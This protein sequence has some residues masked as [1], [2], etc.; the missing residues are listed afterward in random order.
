MQ[1]HALELH[2]D[3]PV[4]TLYDKNY[5]QNPTLSMFLNHT[6][7]VCRITGRALQSLSSKLFQRIQW[8]K[9]NSERK[10]SLWWQNLKL[11]KCK[12][13]G[14]WSVK[15]HQAG[16]GEGNKPNPAFSSYAC[17]VKK[18][19]KSKQHVKSINIWSLLYLNL[20]VS[21]RLRQ[22]SVRP[23]VC[24][25]SMQVCLPAVLICNTTEYV[26]NSLVSPATAVRRTHTWTHRT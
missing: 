26:K 20:R 24:H 17:C 23:S 7:P 6:C 22:T 4:R 12:I 1:V 10:T 3:R 21:N 18:G 16:S 11:R 13:Y 2:S 19:W 14:N 15:Q 5:V 25:T 8:E 9:I